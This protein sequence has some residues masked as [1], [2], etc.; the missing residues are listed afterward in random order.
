MSEQLQ[1]AVSSK[2]H[3]QGN[4]NAPIVLVEYGDYQCPY[5]GQ[6]YPIVKAVQKAMGNDLKF[7]FRNFPLT[8]MHPNAENAAL[9]AEAAAMENKFWQM[10]DMLYENQQQLDPQDL[11]AY[12]KKIGLNASEF[13]KDSE[14][15][16]ASTKVESDFES[17]VK[18]GVNGTPSF[19]INGVKYDG[20]WDEESLTQ[21]L[22]GQLQES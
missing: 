17:G 7:V 6:A 1:P 8:E 16:A 20:S 18:S 13:Q 15:D 21:Y 19:Y 22:K 11:T 9:A 14:S 4:N 2:D 12:A 10:H 3:S 5:C